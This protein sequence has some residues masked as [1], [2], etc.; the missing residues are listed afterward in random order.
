MAEQNSEKYLAGI[1]LPTRPREA[2]LACSPHKYEI[3][4]QQKG[5]PTHNSP[6][7]HFPLLPGEPLTRHSYI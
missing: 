1:S 3:H 5:S 4:S 7:Q 6:V 2:I